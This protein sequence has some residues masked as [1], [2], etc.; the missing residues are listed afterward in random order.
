M[1]KINWLWLSVAIL[2]LPLSILNAPV[3]MAKDTKLERPETGEIARKNEVVYANLQAGGLLEEIYV[4]NAFELKK[5]G[6]IED[7]GQYEVVKNLTDTAAIEQDKQKLTMDVAADTF[8]YQ[9]NLPKG[10]SLPWTFKM[11]YFL[12]GKKMDPEAMIGKSGDVEIQL[13][14][15]QDDK[16]QAVFSNHYLLQ[17]TLPL[18]SDHF[19]NIEADE[20]TIA[21]AGKDKQIAFTVMPEEEAKF[22]IQAKT[23][24][25]EIDGFEITALP[26]SISV[27][28][29]DTE[30]LDDE[31]HSLTDAIGE[32]KTGIGVLRDGMGELSNGLSALETGSA[33]YQTGIQQLDQSGKQLTDASSEID[34]AVSDVYQGIRRTSGIAGLEEL[35][36]VDQ[37]IGELVTGMNELADGLEQLASQYG[38]A[39]KAL[40]TALHQIPEATITEA[41][42][43]ALYQ[44]GADVDV[45]DE[46]VATYEAAQAIKATYDELEGAFDAVESN[47]TTYSQTTREVAKNVQSLAD[48]MDEALGD[49]DVDEG[50]EELIKGLEEMSTSYHQFHE[51]LIDYTGGVKELANQYGDLHGGIGEA[52]EGVSELHDGAGELYKGTERL[53]DATATI[54]E[55]MREEIDAMISQYDHSDFDAVSFVSDK[56]DEEIDSV[57]FVVHTAS[58]QEEEA[59]SSDEKETEEI[60]FMEKWKNLFR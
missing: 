14:V 25:F 16:N 59:E 11:T 52:K 45:I 23:D 40:K 50:L 6:V 22:S 42:I 54:P 37:S 35:E 44:S 51:G 4:V 3:V 49:M 53:Y 7:F 31:F 28:G 58:L 36:K 20:A 10:H 55:E 1:K 13:E 30:G 41:D 18:H 21:N 26:S 5:Q 24:K 9:G 15:E 33:E 48:G 17:I 12:D 38:K 57:Q 2:F 39:N 56:N 60:G 32:I 34:Q 27:D 19:K 46:L 47:V 29:P 43:E 8:Y